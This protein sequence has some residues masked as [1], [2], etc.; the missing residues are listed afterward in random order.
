MG[1]RERQ[2]LGQARGRVLHA[3]RPARVRAAVWGRH[4]NG[5]RIGDAGERRQFWVLPTAP[6]AGLDHAALGTD[7][8]AATLRLSTVRDDA[9]WLEGRMCAL[10]LIRK[11]VAAGTWPSWSDQ[12]AS[13]Y[14]LMWVGTLKGATAQ[15]RAWRLECEGPSSLLRRVLNANRGAEWKPLTPVLTLD[16][17]EDLIASAFA[18][19][20]S[21]MLNTVVC[22][23]S[24]YT[25][26]DQL[27]S[28]YTPEQTAG[29][30]YSIVNGVAGTAG[31]M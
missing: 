9:R 26:G 16:T 22:G 7:D 23:T 29:E 13:G 12:Y 25:G 5:E 21:D 2:E 17:G 1:E 8:G 30:V 28:G 31:R 10:Y 15:S 18:Y 4:V 14:S 24:A 11:D 20:T 3:G 27:T 19:T 6:P